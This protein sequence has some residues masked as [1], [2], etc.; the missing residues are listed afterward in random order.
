MSKR[1]NKIE[2]SVRDRDDTRHRSLI[3]SHRLQS[4]TPKYTSNCDSHRIT[5]NKE[6]VELRGKQGIRV[7]RGLLVVTQST[8]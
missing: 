4:E 7:I 5:G 3:G 8:S 2:G 1:F 6:G